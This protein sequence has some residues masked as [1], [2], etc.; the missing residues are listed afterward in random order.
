M[1]GA[2]YLGLAQQKL[3]IG[4]HN[5]SRVLHTVRQIRRPDQRLECVG[6][7]RILVTATRSGLSPTEENKIPKPNTT[8]SL[9][10]RSLRNR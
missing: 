7:D 1:M 5:G 6:K 10:Q 3:K 2:S 9:R 4:Q 8:S